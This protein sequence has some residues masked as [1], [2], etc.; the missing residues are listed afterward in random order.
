[1]L[2]CFPFY[3]YL[4]ASFL[5]ADF[6]FSEKLLVKIRGLLVFLIVVAFVLIFAG[7]L[8]LKH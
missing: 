8:G 1:M 5:Q 6:L 4:T 7:F 2:F 3:L